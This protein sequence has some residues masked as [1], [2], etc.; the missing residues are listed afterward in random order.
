[1][2]GFLQLSGEDYYL[3]IAAEKSKLVR[4]FCRICHKYDYTFGLRNMVS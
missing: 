3:A 1:M 4:D 2:K